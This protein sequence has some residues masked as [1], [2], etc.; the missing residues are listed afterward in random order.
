MQQ[1]L[2]FKILLFLALGM[3]L[4][5]AT[6][7]ADHT[8][9]TGINDKVAHILTFILLGFLTQQ[10]FPHL[11]ENW[12]SYAWLLTFGLGIEIIQY[13][14]PERSLSLLDLAADAAGLLVAYALMLSIRQVTRAR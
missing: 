9:T 3:T 4:V 5:I 7:Q 10:A 6:D 11:R 1:T 8:A 2:L 13:F 14:I 12:R